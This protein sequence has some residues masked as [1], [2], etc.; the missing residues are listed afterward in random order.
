MTRYTKLTL[1]GT[2][3][4][5]YGLLRLC[6]D[7]R[8]IPVW[9]ESFLVGIMTSVTSDAAV[10]VQGDRARSP[11]S[12]TDIFQEPVE[13]QVHVMLHLLGRH[14]GHHCIRRC[15][16][17]VRTA[18]WVTF[19]HGVAVAADPYRFL[20]KGTR[21]LPLRT[22]IHIRHTG[23][24]P[25]ARIG[26]RLTR[27]KLIVSI[28]RAVV[29]PYMAAK[30]KLQRVGYLRSAQETPL[31]SGGR[32]AGY[33]LQGHVVAGGAGEHSILKWEITR[34]SAGHRVAWR[35]INRVGL[36]RGEPPIMTRAA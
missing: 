30:A 18:V 26:L 21:G 28:K 11:L 12:G 7:R 19:C 35:Q 4:M 24:T 36:S 13:G 31:R 5:I 14:V 1:A 16:A 23:M 29:L 22:G 27:F 10:L 9:Q 20:V 33:A 3:P 25:D 6:A 2:E 17:H 32:W 15:C 8:R 34:N